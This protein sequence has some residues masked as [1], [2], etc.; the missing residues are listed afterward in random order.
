VDS[1]AFSDNGRMAA[2]GDHNGSAYVWD[3][4]RRASL[5]LPSSTLTGPGCKIVNS[6]AF[7]PGGTLAA[8]CADGRTYLWRVG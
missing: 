4:G 5:S 6:V 2:T 1:V 7:S 3:I 8:G